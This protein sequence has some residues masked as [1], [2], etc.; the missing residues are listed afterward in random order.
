MLE[1]VSIRQSVR[2]GSRECRRVIAEGIA[3]A[4]LDL[5]ET[6]LLADKRNDLVATGPRLLF[7]HT[8]MGAVPIRHDDQMALT[9]G[10]K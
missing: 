9:D 4:V 10:W 8:G 2:K 7:G 3:S 6:E 5:S 1:P